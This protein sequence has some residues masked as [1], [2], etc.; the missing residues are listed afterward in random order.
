ML[1]FFG[2]AD[3]QLTRRSADGGIDFYGQAPFG[4]V[5][6]SKALPAGVE[7]DLKVWLVGQAKHYKAMKVS[8]K[9]LRELVG[10]TELAKSH[11][12]AGDTDPN[13]GFVPRL[14]DP[15][16]YMLVTSGEF[17]RDSYDLI[18]GSG[19]IVMDQMMLAQFLADN[20][21]GGSD[22]TVTTAELTDWL[23]KV[24]GVAVSQPA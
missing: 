1:R 2:V 11:I 8:V 19:I 17:T 10:S 13:K 24:P 14:C 3:P 4:K 7:K 12:F 20:G 23:G 21:V 18:S 5:L 9:D 15:I 16:F 6:A 22:G